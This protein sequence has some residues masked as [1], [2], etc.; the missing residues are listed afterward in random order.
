MNNEDKIIENLRI[1]I[2]DAEELGLVRTE[3]GRVIT[4]AVLVD[5]SVVLTE[6]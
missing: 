3:T 4:G 1:A 5:G 2:Q 6:D